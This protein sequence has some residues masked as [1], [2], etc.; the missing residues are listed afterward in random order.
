MFPN[1]RDLARTIFP[2]MFPRR[3]M[4][5]NS[6]AL[7][8]R[9]DGIPVTCDGQFGMFSTLGPASS[10]GQ[11]ASYLQRTVWNALDNAFVSRTGRDAAAAIRAGLKRC[12]ESFAAIQG[13]SPVRLFSF[14]FAEMANPSTRRFRCGIQPVLRTYVARASARR[15][16]KASA[17]FAARTPDESLPR[18]NP[19]VAIDAASRHVEAHMPSASLYISSNASSSA[20]S[21]LSRLRNAISFRSTLVS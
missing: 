1:P 17:T 4:R 15:I 9:Q 11:N 5:P 8:P 18:S 12:L 21:S 2:R 14:D 3:A 6:W 16:R 19:A 7:D 20:T 10:T 13:G